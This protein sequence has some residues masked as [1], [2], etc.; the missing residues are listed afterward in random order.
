MTIFFFFD[1]HYQVTFTEFLNGVNKSQKDK[2]RKEERWEEKLREREREREKKE[3]IIK[4][5][6]ENFIEEKEKIE[7]K[8]NKKKDRNEWIRQSNQSNQGLRSAD[9]MD[10]AANKRQGNLARTCTDTKGRVVE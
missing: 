9:Y 1:T 3:D 10:Q 2:G 5:K 4:S 8:T 7:K 6:R